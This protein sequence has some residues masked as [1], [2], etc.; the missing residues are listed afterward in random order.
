VIRYF[1]STF[2]YRQ[3]IP[4]SVRVLYYLLKPF[5]PRRLQLHVRRKRSH[6]LL[7]AQHSSWP[8]D[9]ESAVKPNRWPGWPENRQFALILTHDVEKAVGLGH[10]RSIVEL[11]RELGFRSAFNFV[12]NDYLIPEGFQAELSREGFEVGVHGLHHDGM[13]FA[14][15]RIFRRH[16]KG[17]NQCLEQWNA[18]G[19][20]APSMHRN[21]EWI[22]NLNIRY[23][24]STFDT[25]PFEPQP[26]AIRTIFPMWV[27]NHE[28][29]NAYI[30][31]PYTLAQDFTLFVLMGFKDIGIWM[32]KLD[33]IAEH[34]GMAL[35]ITHPDYMSWNGSKPGEEEYPS[36]YYRAFLDYI[37]TKYHGRY[38][39][40]LP[41]EVADY[42][43]SVIPSGLPV[44]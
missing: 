15:R 20:R 40:A 32:K 23:D 2:I 24:S 21:L 16:A 12:G 42:Y 31:L 36:D 1:R 6:H 27:V 34:G 7:A 39:N 4:A 29:N 5:I 35:L 13:M 22:H 44:G 8:I 43:A 25:D 19:F 18:T 14:T 10:V 11:E 26:D 33:W 30:E 38:W 3:R 17:I 28:K 9:P 37:R 41:R